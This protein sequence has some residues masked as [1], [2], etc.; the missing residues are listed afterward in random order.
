MMNTTFSL[1]KNDFKIL[2]VKFCIIP[3]VIIH[4]MQVYQ[5][6]DSNA[7]STCK[8]KRDSQCLSSNFLLDKGRGTCLFEAARQRIDI[9][10][11]ET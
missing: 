5:K 6:C 10:S 3:L 4:D 11:R 9:E 1:S 2:L 7:G 8:I